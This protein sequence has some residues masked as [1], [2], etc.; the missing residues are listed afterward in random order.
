LAQE[1]LVGF[2]ARTWHLHGASRTVTVRRLEITMKKAT[3]TVTPTEQTELSSEERQI[4]A[5]MKS[6]AKLVRVAL[7]CLMFG[8]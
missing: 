5:R 6:R 1:L 8:M 2:I 3:Q 4:L 7:P